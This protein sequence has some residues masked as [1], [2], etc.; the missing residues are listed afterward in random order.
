M[1]MFLVR[2]LIKSVS[3]F[4]GGIERLMT[5]NRCSSVYKPVGEHNGDSVSWNGFH[6]EFVSQ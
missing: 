5:E 1:D 2:H 6:S 4:L 3:I